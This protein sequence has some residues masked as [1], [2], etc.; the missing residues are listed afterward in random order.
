MDVS[1]GLGTQVLWRKAFLPAAEL[2]EGKTK[3]ERALMVQPGHQGL[4]R[5]QEAC[6]WPR[7]GQV[8]I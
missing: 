1:L 2:C 7:R 4:S 5:G 3:A 6:L 8:P